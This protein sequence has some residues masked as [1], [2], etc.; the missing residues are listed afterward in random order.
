MGWKHAVFLGGAVLLLVACDRVT[1]PTAGVRQ[2]PAAA[3]AKASG[4]GKVRTASED[5][6]TGYN[7]H[8]G[9]TDSTCADIIQ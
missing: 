7:V 9:G 2:G 1:A 8:S 3:A 5:C 6:R 4:G